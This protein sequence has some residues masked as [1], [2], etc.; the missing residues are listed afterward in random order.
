QKVGNQLVE[1]L[2]SEARNRKKKILP[3]CP[4]AKKI[5]ENDFENYQDILH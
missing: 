5:T 2:A 3:L 1:H 4:F